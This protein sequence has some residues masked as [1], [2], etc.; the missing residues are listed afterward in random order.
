MGSSFKAATNNTTFLQDLWFVYT[1]KK[2][3]LVGKTY[4]RNNIIKILLSNILLQDSNLANFLLINITNEIIIEFFNYKD[5]VGFHGVTLR[6]GLYFADWES[7]L[8]NNSCM[9]LR[10]LNIEVSLTTLSLLFTVLKKNLHEFNACK[11]KILDAVI[12]ELKLPIKV[13][14]TLYIYIYIYT[15]L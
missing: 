9:R 3:E 5:N 1:D 15:C 12:M 13:A 6:L 8:K 10:I 2:V 4:E 14:W 7:Y 11:Q